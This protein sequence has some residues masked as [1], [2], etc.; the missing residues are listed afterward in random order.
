MKAGLPG[1]TQ[2]VKNERSL[3]E[4]SMQSFL[5]FISEWSRTELDYPFQN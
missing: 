5:F 3:C 4:I 2:A 1:R